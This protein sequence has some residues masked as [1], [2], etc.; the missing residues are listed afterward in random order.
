MAQ[1]DLTGATNPKAPTI[2]ASGAFNSFH[3]PNGVDRASRADDP[4]GS[5][6]GVPGRTITIASTGAFVRFANPA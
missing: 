3:S 4:A 6:D 2:D 1:I 5:V